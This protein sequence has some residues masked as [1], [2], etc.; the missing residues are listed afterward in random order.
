MRVALLCTVLLSSTQAAAGPTQVAAGVDL[1]AGEFIPNH[2][3]DGN[4]ILF[5]T[6]AG[7]V[8]MDTGRHAAHTQKILDFARDSGE[9]IVAIVNSHWHLDHIGGNARI[10]AAYPDVR[11]YASGALHDALGG[12]L[13]NYHKQ[14]EAMIAQA[15]DDATRQSYRD[16][17]AI[18]DAGPKL[19]PDDL[20]T[21]TRTVHIG[22]RALELHLEKHSVTAGDVWVFDPKTQVLAAGDLVTL[23]VP[24]LDTA[25]P[26]HWKAA[27]GELDRAK[28]KQLVPGHGA[29]LSHAQFSVYRAAFDKL[30]ACS[31]SSAEKQACIEGWTHDAEPLLGAIDRKF[32]ASLLDYYIDASLRG[33]A[34]KTAKLCGA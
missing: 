33:D 19:A 11:V 16:E 4:S 34:A 24:F 13:A 14:L 3:P 7:L 15:P 21:N 9:P 32:V 20:I 30:L 2:Q 27:L 25:C 12:F 26:Q 23:P 6:D 17:I 1:I 10:R 22:G 31:A 29:A 18:I 8:V 5:H 28:F